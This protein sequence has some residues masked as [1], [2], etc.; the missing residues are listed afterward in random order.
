MIS[1]EQLLATTFMELTDT[2]GDD[3]DVLDFLQNMVGRSTEILA[4]PPPR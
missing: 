3:F 1:R 2:T 4:R